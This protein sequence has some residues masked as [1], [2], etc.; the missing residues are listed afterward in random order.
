M[1]QKIYIAGKVTGLE[2]TVVENNFNTLKEYFTQKG[3]EVVSPIDIVTDPATEWKAAMKICIAALMDC[4]FIYPMKNSRNSKGA[5]LEITIA[6]AF[7]IT[8]IDSAIAD[9][10]KYVSYLDSANVVLNLK[11]AGNMFSI[12]RANETALKL[13]N[14]VKNKTSHL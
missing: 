3:F 10:T 14:Q 5:M 7:G 12:L 8:F 9:I 6:K 1:K 2:R 13:L 4:D 11:F